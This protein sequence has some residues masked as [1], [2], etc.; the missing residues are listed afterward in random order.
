M[1]HNMHEWR[2]TCFLHSATFSTYLLMQFSVTLG[3]SSP[4]AAGV[5]V[6]CAATRLCLSTAQ[7][8]AMCTIKSFFL[9]Q[10]KSNNTLWKKLH[11]LHSCTKKANKWRNKNTNTSKCV[12]NS[13][14]VP[15][16]SQKKEIFLHSVHT[17]CGNHTASCP[18]D[19]AGSSTGDKGTGASCWP[20]TSS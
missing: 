5:T 4:R 3:A 19:T 16:L 17:N 9:V 1:A 6:Y 2:A 8:V 10:V 11:Y 20:F 18:V 7:S 14:K 15:F 12:G 13:Q